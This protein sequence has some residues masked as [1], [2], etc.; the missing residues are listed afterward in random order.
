MVE[1]AQAAEFDGLSESTAAA[2]CWEIKQED[3]TAADGTFWVVTPKM[4]APQ[5][6]YC[7]M[8]T[9]GGGWVL[10]GK[11][12][13]AWVS[14]YDGKGSASALA[15]S[16]VSPMSAATTQYPSVLIDGLLN[17]QRVDSLDEGVRLKRA[18][19]I[20]GQDWQEVRL[21]YA[22]MNGWSWTFGAQNPLGWYEFDGSRRNGGNS[23]NF[24]SDQSYN[25]VTSTPISSQA[26]AVGFTYGNSVGGS[27]NSASYMYSRTNDSGPAIPYT[28]V[29]LR[30]KLTAEMAGWERIGD[31]GIAAKTVPDGVRSRALNSPWGVSG[32]G[33]SAQREGD[34]EVQAMVE[35]NGV[36][37]IGGNFRYVQRTSNST[38]SDRVEQPYLAAF[39]SVTGEFIR[40]FTPSFNGSVMA[41]AALPN[42]KIV[43]GGSFSTVNGQPAYL[44]ALDP[45]TG[46]TDSSWKVAVQNNTASGGVSIRTLS[47]E[48]GWLYLAG[49]FTHLSGGSRYGTFNYMRNAGRVAVQDGTQGLNWNPEFNGTVVSSDASDDGG[50]FYAAGYFST[51]RSVPAFKAAAV[52]TATG[53]PLATPTWEPQWSSSNKNYQQAIREVDDRVWVGGSEHSLFAF[54]KASFDRVRTYIEY[55]KGDLQTITTGNGNL[56]AGCH[57]NAFSYDGATQWPQL[58]NSWDRADSIGWIGEWNAETGD[59]NPHF[60]PNIGM[61]LGSGPWA[62]LVNDEG[63]L[64]VGGDI[65]TVS[66]DSSQGR[67]AGGFARFPKLDSQAPSTPSNPS[68]S[69]D[70]TDTVRLSWGAS[71]D[72]GGAVGYQ[73]LRDDRVIATTTSRALTVPKG[74]ENRFFVRA[75]D[76]SGNLSATTSPLKASGGNAAP[77]PEFEFST[78]EKSVSLDARG[79]TDDG[80]IV[81]YSWDY[82]DESTGDGAQSIHEYAS[83]GSYAVT[84]QVEDDQGL[85][86]NTTQTVEVVPGSPADE[87]GAAVYEDDAIIFWR[88]NEAS[89]SAVDDSSSAVNH[90]NYFGTTEFG[91]DGV[92]EHVPGTAVTFSGNNN[93]AASTKRFD[94]VSVYSL[95]TWFKTETTVGGKLIG[96]GN[97]QDSPSSS[98]DRHVYMMNNGKLAFGVYTGTENLAT[99]TD[100]YNDGDWHHMVATQSSEG[101]K[102]FVDGELAADN[103]ETQAENYAGYWRLGGDQVWAGASSPY[104]AGSL[105]EAAVY[106]TALSAAEI[107]NHYRLGVG[108]PPPANQDPVAEFTLDVEDLSIVADASQSVDPD[109]QITDHA[110]DFGDGETGTGE[111][112]DHTY[113]AGGNYDVTLTVTDNRGGVASKT[114][115]VDVTVPSEPQESVP[116]ATDADWFWSYEVDAPP[117]DWKASGFQPVGWDEAA[118]PLGWGSGVVQ[119]DIRPDNWDDGPSVRARAAYFVTDFQ[120]E[121]AGKVIKLQL[122]SVADDGVVIYVNGTEVARS[123]M[124]VGTITHNSYASSARRYTVAMQNPV[125]VEVPVALLI[126]GT[127][128]ISA[129]THV[130]YRS[131]PDATFHLEATLTSR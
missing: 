57:C 81:R 54:D 85:V 6:V 38:G 113:A 131:T 64:W 4:D 69:A 94:P 96:F 115:N 80:Q 29:Y 105:D 26:Y 5:Q 116:V 20:D 24:G 118:A 82:G 61:R 107:A 47:T 121:D 31:N 77:V 87:Y 73:V 41:L 128:R 51:S 75:S 33:H 66:A 36:V 130:N 19:S 101:M 90:G 88:L 56:Y 15:T 21:S 124:P 48:D 43:A 23:N 3:S 111:T 70:Q 8:T 11:G 49:S 76:A 86:R 112:T 18:K 22:K 42:G 62:S 34:V 84:L 27:T 95:E 65:T 71:S 44:A 83:Y 9:D 79:S 2:S 50:R 45:V 93:W 127:N 78:N 46:Q 120:I 59:Y 60:T 30:P 14:D 98:Y 129:E 32:L 110:W 58:G 16:G 67:W 39:N 12:R 89:G 28:E 40:T 119:S 91:E 68:L 104:F 117:S 100:P 97:N 35:S 99:T 125:E 52:L 1:K 53:A 25:R 103:P 122:E 114:V 123:N 10:V 74:G 72:S 13:N 55:D 126:D 102:L 109:G 92:S 17:G 37:Y 108:A 63:T 7:D 106:S